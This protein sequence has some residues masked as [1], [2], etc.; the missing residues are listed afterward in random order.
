MKNEKGKMR[1]TP[2]AP[3]KGGR[4]SWVLCVALF[5]IFHFSFLI[6]SCARQGY[7]SGGPKD[8][9]PPQTLGTKPANESRNFAER[10]FYIQFD[11]YVVLKN[12][13]QNVII[14]PPMAQ[15]P[16]FTTK[17]K[18]VLVKIKDT[19]QANTT[20]LFQFKEAIADFT[21]GNLL[22]TYEYVFSTGGM[23]DTMMLSGR[24]ENARDGKPWAETVTVLAY[25]DGDSVAS[26]VTRADKRGRFAFHYIPAGSYR[27]VALEDKNRDLKVGDDEAVAWLEQSFVA[28]DSVDSTQMAT[29]RI[30]A[31]ERRKQRVVSSEMPSKGRITIV[32]AM[33]MRNPSVEGEK[34]VQRLNA[35]GD[36]L[37][38]WCVNPLCDSTVLV[39]SDEGL[40]DTLKLRY[41]APKRNRGIGAQ[42]Q[43]P[44]LMSSLCNGQSAYYDKLQ[45]AFTNPIVSQADSLLAE[46]MWMKDSSKSMCAV[47]LDTDGMKATIQAQV[48]SD[49]DYTIRIPA[50]MFTDLYGTSSDSLRITLKPKDFA[51]L[52]VHVDNNSGSA[53]VVELLDTKD[54][55][56]QHQVLESSGTARFDHI[57]AGNY[58]LRAVID[59][60]GN[61]RW[62]VGDYATRRQPE[63]CVMYGKTLQLR[64][65]WEM[66]ESWTVE[67]GGVSAEPAS[68][69]EIEVEERSETQ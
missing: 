59:D 8:S 69:Q 48:K 53:L 4:L 33:P 42:P 50:G 57:G 20:Y 35:K 61:G 21:E 47:V 68:Q 54:T 7:P 37:N 23:M 66:E 64:E 62:T 16:E 5:F 60:D 46:V 14:S 63:E 56:V 27:L 36:T 40:Q 52:T 55:V 41:R 34:T 17:G 25:R 13:E 11:E 29:L 6:S 49:E 10:Q 15:K 28:A 12:A 19:L 39:V 65:R 26:R 58:R 31:P 67:R 51:I 3:L 30:S 22:P 43:Q 1:N 24:V 9:E 18:G 32:T 44:P 2:S 38:I 45:L